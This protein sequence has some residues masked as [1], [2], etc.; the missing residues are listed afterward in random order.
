MTDWV[1]LTLVAIAG[2][3][4]GALF[5][6]GLLW[7]VQRGLRSAHPAQWFF[8]SM[9]ARTAIVLAGF[10]FTAGGDWKKVLVCLAGF[11]VARAVVTRLGAAHLQ[12][13][14]RHAS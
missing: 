10:W 2:A 5:F 3:L 8:F 9:V 11:A 12:K 1:Q 6:G 14:A 13:E 4:L 7:T